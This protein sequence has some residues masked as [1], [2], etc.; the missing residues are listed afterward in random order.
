MLYIEYDDAMDKREK[1]L[2]KPLGFK[3]EKITDLEEEEGRNS[4][5]RIFYP[6]RTDK[7]K[8]IKE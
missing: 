7:F 5:F 2:E 8:E 4:M 6:E 1:V 3:F